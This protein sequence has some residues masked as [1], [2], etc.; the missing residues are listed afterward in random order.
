MNTFLLEKTAKELVA[1]GKG[2]LA[3][4][5]SKGTI[6]K[7]FDTIGVES[8]PE[9]HRVYRQLLFKTEGIEEFI[10]GVILF[11]ETIR[12]T[13]DEG[14]PFAEYLTAKGI[15]PGIK[16]DKGTVDMVNFPGEK[17]TEGLDGLR[18]RLSEYKDLKA[19]FTKW[20]AVIGIGEG[21]PTSTCINANAE[22]M[23]L[24]AAY[25]QEA[26]LVPIVEP[27]V[28]MDGNFDIKKGE[29]VT[30]QTLK[31]VFSKLSEYRI[32]FPGMLLKTNWV[33]NGRASGQEVSETEVA[34][35]TLRVLKE[36]V[37][38]EVPGIVFLS[39]GDT[40]QEST[41]NLNMMNKIGGPWQLSFSFGR[42]LQE[43]VLKTW[44]GKE[45]NIKEAQRKFYQR[46]KLNSLARKGEYEKRM[47]EELF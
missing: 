29:E 22:L 25:S 6:K 43:P 13:T 8:T 31:S 46:A 12:Q 33:R 17:L 7:R 36:V 26:D 35:A 40:P 21:I 28:L 41:A 23:A 44:A 3:A 11:D 19:K 5:E 4:D 45:E 39:G 9:N 18:Q 34:E 38:P 37:P 30:Y 24:F 32:Y 14:V 20:R 10:S 15:I 2:I 47:E 27:E 1:E 16:V 42:A